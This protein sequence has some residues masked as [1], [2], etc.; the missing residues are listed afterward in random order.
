MAPGSDVVP[1]ICQLA[2]LVG[3]VLLSCESFG[4]TSRLHRS[5]VIRVRRQLRRKSGSSGWLPMT[6]G[7]VTAIAI[8]VCSVILLH[9]VNG[10]VA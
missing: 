5:I 1:A 3:I 4:I 2:G 6:V 8:A 9:A 10:N 7:T